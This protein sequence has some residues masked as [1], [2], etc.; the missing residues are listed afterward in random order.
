VLKRFVTKSIRNHLNL[1]DLIVWQDRFWEHTIR[2]ERDMQIHFE[3]IL[4]NPVKHS[5]VESVD[6]WKWSSIDSE[7]SDHVIKPSLEQID[8]LNQ[9]GNSF[10][11]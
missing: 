4:Y 6:Q 10:G 11:E 8:A 2:D 7:S 1:P 3:Y 9:K 5:Y